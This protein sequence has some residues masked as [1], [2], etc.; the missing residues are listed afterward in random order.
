MTARLFR[1]AE[2]ALPNSL[3]LAYALGGYAGGLWLMATASW[4]V[5]LAATLWLAHALI[6]AAYL[7]HEFAHGTIFT[8]PEAN[9]RGGVL[10]TWLTGS[11][12][13]RYEQLRRKHMRHHVDRADVISL[14]IKALLQSSPA[15]LR[16]MVLALEWA[17][18]PAV[19]LLM[20]AYVIARPFID[21]QR[22]EIGRAHV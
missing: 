8:R 7:F 22:H 20:H 19:E 15:I 11:C 1:H 13:A 17:Y 14:D 6:I 21:P 10:M 3:A 2:G 4:P 16:R 12:Y 5:A 18:L 9:S